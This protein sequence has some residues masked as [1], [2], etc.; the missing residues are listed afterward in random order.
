MK[1]ILHSL[2]IVKYHTILVTVKD[3]LAEI[4]DKPLVK[5]YGHFNSATS[6]VFIQ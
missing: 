5:K 2:T 6:Y 4:I 1:T 3:K